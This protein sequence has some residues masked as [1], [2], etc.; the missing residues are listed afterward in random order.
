M[1]AE[2][3]EVSGCCDWTS[4]EPRM[5]TIIDLERADSNIEIAKVKVADADVKIVRAS[6]YIKVGYIDHFMISRCYTWSQ[7]DRK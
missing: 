6:N 3:E 7:K 1:E 5:D 4:R 2:D